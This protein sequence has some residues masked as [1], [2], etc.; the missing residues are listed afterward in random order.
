MNG[1]PRTKALKMRYILMLSFALFGLIG[2]SSQTGASQD[3]QT[4]GAVVASGVIGD[5]SSTLRFW[6]EGQG[7]F[8]DDSSRFNQGI[9]RTALGIAVAPRTTLW[10]GYAFIPNNPPGRGDTIVEHR[11]WQQLTWSAAT[12]LLGFTLATRTRLEQRTVE[13]T[14]DTGW[15]FRQFAKLSRPI[16]ASKWLYV[17]LW[18]EIFLNFNDT[19]W[20]A[21][22]GFDQ[23]RLFGG[24][25]INLSADAKA[26]IGY[27]HQLV[28]LDGREDQQN[29]ILS[30]TVLLSY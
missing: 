12:P 25:G 17:S 7:R 19:D 1:L 8:N 18:D 28:R 3:W 4:W 9:V 27:L 2:P 30:L 23:N 13:G 5:Q 6:L 15:R 14:D 16:A 22:G 29:H 21:N 20:G 26:E 11:A 24:I 10:A